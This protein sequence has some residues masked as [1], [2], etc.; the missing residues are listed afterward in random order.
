MMPRN[1]PFRLAPNIVLFSS[2]IISAEYGQADIDGL[3][4]ASASAGAGGAGHLLNELSGP[5]IGMALLRAVSIHALPG[6]PEETA[7]AA[8]NDRQLWKKAFEVSAA[9]AG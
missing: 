8:R 9:A 2:S 1:Y 4:R 7:A 6:N 3:A 5:S